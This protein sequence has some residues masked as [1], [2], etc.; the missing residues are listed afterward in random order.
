MPT[1]KAVRIHQFGDPDVLRYEDAPR[2]DPASG[3]VLIRVH[4]AGTNPVD[5]KT[6]VG[7]GIAGRLDIAFP[8]ITGGRCGARRR[9]A[10]E[11]ERGSG[12][13]H[14]FWAQPGLPA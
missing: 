5:R 2:P 7:R 11:V 8:F 3:E 1:M 6:R 9:A 12:H 10:G 4:A 14:R 13:R